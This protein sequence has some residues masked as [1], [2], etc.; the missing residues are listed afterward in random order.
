MCYFIQFYFQL[1]SFTEPTGE[2]NLSSETDVGFFSDSKGDNSGEFS[3]DKG[4]IR[5][6]ERESN[7]GEFL[8]KGDNQLGE[9]GS[10]SGEFLYKGDNRLGEGGSNAASFET[11]E[12][13]DEQ[14][15]R[16][17]ST[18]SDTS[19]ACDAR[20]TSSPYDARETSAEVGVI[21]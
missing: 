21:V 10:T 18:S 14:R 6:E 16:G 13:A 7:S 17:L 11:M 19:L 4:D 20:A 5:L 9:R 2:G 15:P 12:A 1:I 3:D 8:Y